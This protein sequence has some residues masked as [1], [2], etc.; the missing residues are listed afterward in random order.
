MGIE[1]RHPVEWEVVA[2]REGP[3]CFGSLLYWAKNKHHMYG[4]SGDKEERA[5]ERARV[6]RHL[7]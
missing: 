2:S 7:L 5:M 4:G 3:L 1:D 6:H